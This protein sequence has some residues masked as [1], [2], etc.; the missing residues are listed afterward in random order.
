MILV[1]FTL[2]LIA[3][4]MGVSLILKAKKN[5]ELGTC[6]AKIFGYIISVLAIIILVFS[7]YVALK[8]MCLISTE[9][10]QIAKMEHSRGVRIMPHHVHHKYRHR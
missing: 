4:A 9:A 3:L 2:S 10:S 5:S 1:T 6:T 7:A 8:Y